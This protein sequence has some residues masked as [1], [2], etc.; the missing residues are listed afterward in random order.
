MLDL[1][2]TTRSTVS[3]VEGLPLVE[4]CDLYEA[5]RSLDDLAMAL[6]NAPR[7][8]QGARSGHNEA[9]QV[10]DDLAGV[11]SK[12]RDDLLD[13]IKAT[14]PVTVVEQQRRYSTVLSAEADFGLP[15]DDLSQLASA[16]MSESH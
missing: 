9:G 11:L 14:R 6:S 12:A 7:F 3:R 16:L 4:A 13:R 15:P 1:I 2:H 8:W 5:L 10:L